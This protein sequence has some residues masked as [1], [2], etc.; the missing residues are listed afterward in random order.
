MRSHAGAG[1]VLPVWKQLHEVVLRGT[2]D[3]ETGRS[4]APRVLRAILDGGGRVVGALP[5]PMS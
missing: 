5:P 4:T 1:A 2:R 3:R